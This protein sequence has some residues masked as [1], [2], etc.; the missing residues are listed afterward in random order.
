MSFFEVAI[1][2]AVVAAA[3]TAVGIVALVS[4][5]EK[6]TKHLAIIANRVIEIER[7]L[8]ERR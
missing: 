7:S 2:I 5:L 4:V 8:N 1:V 3:I 6:S